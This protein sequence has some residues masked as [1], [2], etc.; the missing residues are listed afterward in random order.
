VPT[1]WTSQLYAEDLLKLHEN[2]NY[3]NIKFHVGRSFRLDSIIHRLVVLP[4]F[5]AEV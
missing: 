3:I 5:V 2:R 1:W 4:H